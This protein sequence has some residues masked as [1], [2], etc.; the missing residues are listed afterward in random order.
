MLSDAAALQDVGCAA[1]V[2][3]AVPAEVGEL[4]SVRLRI[5]VIGIGAGAATAGQ[6]LV[7]HDLLGLSQRRPRF[8]AAYAELRPLMIDALRRFAGDVRARR[9]PAAEHTYSLPPSELAKLRP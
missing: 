8:A 7:W 6:V 3:E 4:L 5:P 9:F 2:C 1:I